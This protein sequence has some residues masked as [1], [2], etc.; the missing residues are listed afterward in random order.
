MRRP[1]SLNSASNT[2]CSRSDCALSRA[3]SFT[4]AS[5]ASYARLDTSMMCS[6]SFFRSTISFSSFLYIWLNTRRSRRRLSMFSRSVRLEASVPLCL[7]SAF[8]RRFCRILICFFTCSAESRGALGP[9]SL[10]RRCI[11]LACSVSSCLCSSISRRFSASALALYF[12]CSLCSRSTCAVTGPRDAA[13]LSMLGNPSVSESGLLRCTELTRRAL[14]PLPE[15][16]PSP[17]RTFTEGDGAI[18]VLVCITV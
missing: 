5:L 11:T 8:S 12:S 14:G 3:I 4:A 17:P 15:T 18:D 9:P 10:A 16:T 6:M 2:W 1:S 7:A 13:I